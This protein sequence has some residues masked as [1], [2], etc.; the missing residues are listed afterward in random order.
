METTSTGRPAGKTG[1]IAAAVMRANQTDIS[2]EETGN[3]FAVTG[4]CGILWMSAALS[5]GAVN[6][7]AAVGHSMACR[8]DRYAQARA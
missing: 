3:G 7:A 6:E 4:A 1:P 8:A 2:L 5:R